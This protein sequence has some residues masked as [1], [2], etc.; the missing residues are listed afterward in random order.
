M[1]RRL[2]SVVMLVCVGFFSA[3]ARKYWRSPGNGSDRPLSMAPSPMAGDRYHSRLGI[4]DS[5]EQNNENITAVIGAT[6]IDG[7]GAG[8]S[9]QTV[10]IR[11]DRIEAVGPNVEPPAGARR[12]DAEGMTLMPGLFDLHTH[13]PY[14]SVSGAANDWPKNLKAYLYCGV[15]SVVD[16][17]AYGEMFPAM[18]GWFERRFPEDPADSDFVYRSTITAKTCD[19]LRLCL[20]A[21]TRSNLGV[22]ATGQSY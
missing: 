19:T 18:Y 6:V 10:V 16:F 1:N 13:L 3:D 17:G 15:T 8:P 2:L 22:Y 4:A 20:P 11:G 21:G 12:I 7:T 9:K 5:L 14:S